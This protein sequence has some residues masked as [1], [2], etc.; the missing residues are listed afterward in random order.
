MYMLIARELN[1][2]STLHLELK[3]FL[4][5]ALKQNVFF[6]KFIECSIEVV[7]RIAERVFI[8]QYT[9]Y[10]LSEIDQMFNKKMC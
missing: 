6:S 1:I 10:K 7:Y 5:W 2:C 3:L 9:C 4:P 8:V